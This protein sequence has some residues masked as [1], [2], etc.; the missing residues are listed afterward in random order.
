MTCKFPRGVPVREHASHPS[1][2]HPASSPPPTTA[3]ARTSPPAGLS[4]PLSVTY[5]YLPAV[6]RPNAPSEAALCHLA[7]RSPHFPLQP[8]LP[9][10]PTAAL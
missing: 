10:A 6:S 2:H 3:A 8:I 1:R 9:A 5:L 7:C 4:A